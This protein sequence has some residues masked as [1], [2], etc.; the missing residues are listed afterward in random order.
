MTVRE[1]EKVPGYSGYEWSHRGPV[2]SIAR[3]LTMRQR[4]NNSGYLIVNVI[5]DDGVK[6]TV[7]VHRMILRA[8]A[9]EPEPGQESL[10]GRGGQQDNRYPENLRWGSRPENIADRVAANPRQEK[11]PTPCMNHDQCG[12]YVVQHGRRCHGCRVDL[13]RA[14]ARLFE[15]GADPEQVAKELNYGSANGAYRV[16]VQLGGLR[17]YVDEAQVT[18]R[19]RYVGDPPSPRSWLRSVIIRWRPSRWNSDAQ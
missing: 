18:P 3:D 9:G 16:A 12:G 2:R 7:L 8:H 19:E 13:G 6:E 11:P 10:H 5:N 15:G 14:A 4:A 1:W 17:C